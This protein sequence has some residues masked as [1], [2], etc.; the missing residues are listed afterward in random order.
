MRILFHQQRSTTRDR[1]MPPEGF[2][3]AFGRQSS[4]T[5]TLESSTIEEEQ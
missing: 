4:A 2:L 5:D 3:W 1:H